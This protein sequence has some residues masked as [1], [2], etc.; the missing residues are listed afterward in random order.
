MAQIYYND[1][2]SAGINVQSPQSE[3]TPRRLILA[4]R[5][6][7]TKNCLRQQELGGLTTPTNMFSFSGN[8]WINMTGKK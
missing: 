5:H 6:E 2:Q 3:S 8:P 4:I 7:K 1:P